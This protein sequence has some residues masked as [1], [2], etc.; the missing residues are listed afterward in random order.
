[1]SEQQHTEYLK[2]KLETAD[3]EV[4]RLENIVLIQQKQIERLME[5]RDIEKKRADATEARIANALI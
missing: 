3:A 5:A 1:M 2:R 4:A